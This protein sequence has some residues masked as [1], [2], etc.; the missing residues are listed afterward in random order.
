MLAFPLRV[1]VWVA[2]GVRFA[3]QCPLRLQLG[4]DLDLAKSHLH[5]PPEFKSAWRQRP[6][7]HMRL[8][9]GTLARILL[10]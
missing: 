2:L 6:S 8:L 5:E 4:Q 9:G 1:K 3:I 7:H 10:L